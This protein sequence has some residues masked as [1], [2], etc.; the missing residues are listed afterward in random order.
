M[1][2][3]NEQDDKTELPT[4]KKLLDAR[5]KGDVAVSREAPLLAAL[6]ATLAVST[7]LLRE[8]A[9]HLADTLARL[10]DDPGRWALRNGADAALLFDVVFRA[11]GTF[12]APVFAIFVVAGLA[13]S[14]AQNMPSVVLGRIEPKLEKLSPA[15]GLD[16]LFGRRGLVEFGKGAAKLAVVGLVVFLILRSEQTRVIDAMFTEP[17]T[18]PDRMLG[19]LTRLMLGVTTAFAVLTAADLVWTRT[20][21]NKRMRMSRREIKDEMRQAEGDPL[22]K[23][24]RRSLALDRSRRRMMADVQRATLVIANPTHFAIALRYVREEGG[25]PIVLAKGQDLIALKIREIAEGNGIEVIENK[26]LA[27][28]MYDH[29]E[30]S[31]AIPPQFYK[32]VAE[33]IHFIQSRKRAGSSIPH[34]RATR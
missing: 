19:I 16:R 24:R 6:L 28:S 27:R 29:V 23:A 31:Q 11:A 15:A 34:E 25:A 9:A 10:L 30:V 21:W 8:G 3:Q 1:S 2:E 26:P 32:A 17:V 5:D 20:A 18:V 13:V 4:E 33:V 12:L 7:L 22:L 14:F